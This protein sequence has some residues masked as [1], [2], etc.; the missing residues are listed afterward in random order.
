[1]VEE[2]KGG[3]GRMVKGEVHSSYYNTQA[4]LKMYDYAMDTC[5]QRKLENG[6]LNPCMTR[7]WPP[8]SSLKS[9]LGQLKWPSGFKGHKSC[10]ITQS[11]SI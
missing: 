11:V 4:P 6:D 9:N 10:T 2:E 1:M 5:I 8:K 3:G 7:Y